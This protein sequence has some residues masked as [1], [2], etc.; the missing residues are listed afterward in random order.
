MPSSAPSSLTSQEPSAATDLKR[1]E[2]AALQLAP[3]ERAALAERLW[4]SVEPGDTLDPAW[5]TEIE[6]RIQEL[7]SGAVECL[8]WDQVMAELRSKY[9]A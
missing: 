9:Q 1:I 4:E 2:I 7:D 8:P 6:R 3:D 5:A